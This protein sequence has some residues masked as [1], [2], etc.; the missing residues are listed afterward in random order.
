[1]EPK[2]TG[3]NGIVND[4]NNKWSLENYPFIIAVIVALG[5]LVVL[6]FF[7]WMK[8]RRKDVFNVRRAT[9]QM[10]PE[11]GE[12][13]GQPRTNRT[14]GS[15]SRTSHQ[16][17]R[18]DDAFWEFPKGKIVI[19][20]ILGEGTFATVNKAK[21]LPLHAMNQIN[22]GIV[23]VKTLK[24]N[25][26]EKDRTNFLNELNVMKKLEPHPYVVQLLGCCTSTEPY[27]LIL[28]YL[29][30]G[31]L[32]G[33]LRKSRGYK[34]PYNTGEYVPTSR[35]TENDLLSF[36]WMVADG[37]TFLAQ[38]EIIHRDLAARNVL[39]GAHN[40][41][42]VSDFGLARE[43]S[44]DRESKARLPVKWMAPEDI[45]AGKCT[46]MS[47]VW[48][49]GILLMEIFTIGDSPYPGYKGKDVPDLV[50]SG[51]RMPRPKH[52]SV[53]IYSVM[54]ECWIIEPR[55]RPR[56]S[57]MAS[58]FK[59]MLVEGSKDYLDLNVFE[60][61][62]YENFDEIKLQRSSIS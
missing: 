29:V 34:D 3:V 24:E 28:E 57:D 19:L 44:Y 11:I 56:F 6:A 36:A 23:A 46:T 1:M 61:H 12:V 39:V 26:D 58:F 40:V 59:E 32:L 35:L 2:T 49:Y 4:E 5:A 47:D 60:D 52:L 31:D 38:N 55:K 48:S 51:Y 22:C 30:G 20:K 50:E 9:M 41:C 62:L 7:V 54:E 45:F 21:I 8:C 15:G 27:L 37:M 53:E 10:G 25:T 33:Y 42:K 17:K 14:P 18:S 13:N 16:I 43:G